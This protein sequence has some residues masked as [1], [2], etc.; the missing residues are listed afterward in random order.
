MAQNAPDGLTEEKMWYSAFA[1]WLEHELPEGTVI[2]DPRWWASKIADYFARYGRPAVAPVAHIGPMVDG[3]PCDFTRTLLRP[4]Y[5]PGDG[6]ADGAQLVNLAW[7][8]PAMGC[9]SLQIVVDNA[10][11]II[12]RQGRPAVAPVAVEALQR[13]RRWGGFTGSTGYSA[14]VVLGVFDW[15][16]GG[17]TGP[18]PPLPVYIAARATTTQEES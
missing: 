11:A 14:D 18:L 8:H 7:W 13:L 4:A 15:I 2:G 12:A 6:S 1:D 3:V 9:D 5:E 10:R 16:D 17:M